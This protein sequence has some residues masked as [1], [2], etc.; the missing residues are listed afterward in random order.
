MSTDFFRRYSNLIVEAELSV[1]PTDD[2]ATDYDEGEYDRE[3]SMAENQLH[4]IIRCAEQLE[5]RISDDENLPEW[6]QEKLAVAEN[7]MQ[8]VLDY[9]LSEKEISKEM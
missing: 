1:L 5:M 7:Y 2:E 3:G 4:T 9:M 8:I 6:V